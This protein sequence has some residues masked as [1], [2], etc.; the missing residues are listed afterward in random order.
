M[1]DFNFVKGD[2][3]VLNDERTIIIDEEK[4]LKYFGND[5]PL[6]KQITIILDEKNTYE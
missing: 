6:G 2:G 3:S 4:A 5:D 1:L